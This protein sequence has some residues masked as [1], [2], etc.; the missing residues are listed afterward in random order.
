MR[1]LLCGMIGTHRKVGTGGPEEGHGRVA[2]V[3]AI[4]PKPEDAVVRD[5]ALEL[6]VDGRQVHDLDIAVAV[7]GAEDRIHAEGLDEIEIFELTPHRRAV[8]FRVYD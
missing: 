3:A 4:A 5:V 1:R 6:V 2:E 8:G 7:A